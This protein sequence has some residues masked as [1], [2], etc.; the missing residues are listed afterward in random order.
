MDDCIFCK[1]NA[2][3]APA[4]I[5]YQD[6]LVMSFLDINPVTPGHTLVIPRVHHPNLSS[7]DEVTGM[8]MFKITMRL[9]SAIRNSGIRCEGI[10]LFLADG[11]AA[12]QDVFHTHL[13]IIPRFEGD[14][15]KISADWGSHPERSELDRMAERIRNSQ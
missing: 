2:G 1:I 14:K 5:I 9:A 7:L 12:F 11:E 13:H 3:D 15:F 8:H 6:E 10:N 4:S